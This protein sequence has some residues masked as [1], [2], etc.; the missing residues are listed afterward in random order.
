MNRF[1]MLSI[2]ALYILLS[3]CT[4]SRKQL[5][6]RDIAVSLIERDYPVEGRRVEYS[7]IDSADVELKGYFIGRIYIDS[8]DSIRI[9]KFHLNYIKTKVDIVDSFTISSDIYKA[10][11]IEG[12]VFSSSTMLK[13]FK[14][15]YGELCG[16]N[17]H[18]PE[19]D[20][21]DRAINDQVDSIIASDLIY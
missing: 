1:A 6:T 21:I 20:S 16:P 19:Q 7:Q 17:T 5:L 12:K 9:E 13:D 15:I 18:T 2:A 11:L 8:S 4:D 3:S 10:L 14:R